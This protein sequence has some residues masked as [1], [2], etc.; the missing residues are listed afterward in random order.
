[1]LKYIIEC[2][3]L[4]QKKVSEQRRQE[5]VSLHARLGV[6]ET[7]CRELLVH[8][9]SSVSGAAVALSA[10]IGRLDGLVEELVA[11]YTISDQEL[12]VSC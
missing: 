11:A 4:L 3:F 12:D 1:M 5:N 10:L 6:L 7:K 2:Y 8:Q 9:G